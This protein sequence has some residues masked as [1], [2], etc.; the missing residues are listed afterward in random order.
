MCH[1][2]E[3]ARAIY[4]FALDSVPKAQAEVLYKQFSAFEKQRGSR[5]GIED[6]VV[7]KARFGYE[8][9]LRARR[10]SA[11]HPAPGT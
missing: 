1:E 7:S 9:T 8:E 2:D 11:H 6:V 4:K 5:E 10:A 3:R